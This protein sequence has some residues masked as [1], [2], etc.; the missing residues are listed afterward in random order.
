MMSGV[1]IRDVDANDIPAIK[2]VVREVWDWAELIEDAEVLDATIAIYLNQVLHAGS[3]GRVAVLNGRVVG[4]IFGSV[5]GAQP[6]YRMFV[7]DCTE[8]TLTLL[9]A[10]EADRKNIHEYLSKLSAVYEQLVSG[11]RDGYGG[12]LDFLVLS[13]EVQGLGIGKDLWIALKAYFEKNGVKSIYLY[14]DAECNFAFYERQ[15]FTKRREREVTF[16]FEGEPE[17]VRQFLYEYHFNSH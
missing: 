13:K 2:E 9:G 7:E 14:S 17:T 10:C 12:T 6:V 16:A 5:N 8:H 3:F 15:G 1:V 11:I 4:V